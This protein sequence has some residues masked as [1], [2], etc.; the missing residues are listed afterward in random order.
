MTSG[1]HGGHLSKG[2]LLPSNKF[3][4]RGKTVWIWLFF[5]WLVAVD[6]PLSY[7][8]LPFETKLWLILF[9]WL[10]PILVALRLRKTLALDAWTVA[11]IPSP[12][13]W[14]ALSIPV[15]AVAIRFI[16]FGDIPRWPLY[17]EMING[18]YAMK[19][20]QHWE[21]RLFFFWTQLLPFMIWLMTA[22]FKILSS[23]LLAIRLLPILIALAVLPLAYGSVRNFFPKSTAF[24]YFILIAFG[25]WALYFGRMAHQGCLLVLWEYLAFFVLGK[26]LIAPSEPSR[27][28]WLIVTGL[29]V[30]TG[31]YTYFSWPVVALLVSLPILATSFKQPSP[32]K[33]LARLCYFLIPLLLVILPLLWS[34]GQG[35]Y[36][37]YF[38]FLWAFKPQTTGVQQLLTVFVCLS[39]FLWGNQPP[40]FYYGPIWGGFFNPVSGGLLIIGL[41]VALS[42]VS[43]SLYRWLLTGLFL[44][45]LPTF[46]SG[47]PPTEMRAIQALPLLTLLAVVGLES[48]LSW[49][50]AKTRFLALT[51]ILFATSGLDFVHLEKSRDFLN[52]LWGFQKTRENTLAYQSL[53]QKYDENKEP[54][55]I[56]THFNALEFRDPALQ[57]ACFPF[58]SVDNPALAGHQATWAAITVNIHY[59]P[60]LAKRFPEGRWIWISRDSVPR[61]INYEGGLML[62]IIPITDKTRPAI[63]TWKKAD[64]LFDSVIQQTM[65]LPPDESRRKA[66]EMYDQLKSSLPLDPLVRSCYWELVFTLHN[67][68]NMYGKPSM[69][70][71][72]I[73]A[74]AML[75]AIQEGYP[76]AHF[77]NELGTLYMIEKKNDLAEKA[78]RSAIRAPLDLTPAKENLASLEGMKGKK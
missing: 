30:G 42:R 68:E 69:M 36:G 70:N 7:F 8:P 75:N 35:V 73:S 21:N 74:Q 31:F 60:F 12:A 66:I 32:A 56:L 10:V 38:H 53:E 43:Q 27:K 37:K 61:D 23:T 17:D 67:W 48:L 58:N 13:L 28:L 65:D 77:Y 11:P 54:G 50:P 29:V 55:V 57:V 19:L 2:N 72:L 20:C 1:P 24:L 76:A 51:A 3:N 45:F 62:G 39:G 34:M 71:F 49:T 6:I 46:L 5:S 44:S 41:I 18:Y 78:F 40:D 33:R 59:Q 25:F 14:I 47:P 9:G 64:V 52:N 15:L 63:E 26:F 22:F 4:L 16:H